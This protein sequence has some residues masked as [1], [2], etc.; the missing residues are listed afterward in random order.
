M[1]WRLQL[2]TRPIRRLDMLLGKPMLLAAWT[3]TDRVTYFDLQHGTKLEDRI[4]D[5]PLA[6]ISNLEDDKWKTY[7]S[8]LTAPNQALLPYVRAR[9]TAIYTSQDGS[10]RLFRPPSGALLVQSIGNAAPLELPPSTP[11][12]SLAMDRA[13]GLIALVDETGHLYLYQQHMR[14]GRF[15]V[16]LKPQP[17]LPTVLCVPE[18]G[19]TLFACDGARLVQV[20]PSGRVR[21]RLELYFPAGM[22]ACA[23]DG[24]T[25]AVSDLESGVLRIYNVHPAVNDFVPTHMSF[26]IDLLADA[27]RAQLLPISSVSGA[28]VGALALNNRGALAFSLSGVVCVTNISRMQMLPKTQPMH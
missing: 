27:K 24:R 26:A 3:Q 11:I 21:R 19:A 28:A 12:L 5:E 14:V 8:N 16:G 6:P 10:V 9:E 2:S 23:P 13:L 25:V 18:S 15:D 22:I 1:A 7:L 4:L 17:D 20:E